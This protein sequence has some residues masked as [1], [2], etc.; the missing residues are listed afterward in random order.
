MTKEELRSQK[1][2]YSHAVLWD[3][4]AWDFSIL[5]AFVP[6]KS[7]V[8]IKPVL[9]KALELGKTVLIARDDIQY[10]Q[11]QNDDLSLSERRMDITKINE[12][13]LMLVPGLYFTPSFDRL[14]R[15]GGFY[16]RSISILPPFI[17]KIGVCKKSQVISCIPVENHDMRVDDL[18]VV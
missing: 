16:D 17:R 6:L 1:R 3:L 7:E 15:G 5:L 8:D 14:G 4:P 18:I 13:A 12:K 9:S 11:I 10:Y 2:D